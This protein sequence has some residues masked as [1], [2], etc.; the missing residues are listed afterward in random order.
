MII[1]Q[2]VRVVKLTGY[3]R[4]EHSIRFMP[5]NNVWRQKISD[6]LK[7]FGDLLLRSA[8]VSKTAEQQALN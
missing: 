5:K 1:L 6:F 4:N 7:F 3:L 8:R 2:K